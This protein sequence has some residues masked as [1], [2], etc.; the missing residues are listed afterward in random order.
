[1]KRKLRPHQVTA[2]GY[3]LQQPH[4]ALFMDMRLGKTLVVIRRVKLMVGRQLV[5]VACPSSAIGSW[6]QELKMEGEDYYMLLGTRKQ[7]DRVLENGGPGW[8]IINKEGHR[9]MPMLGHCPWDVVVIDE[10]TFIKNPRAAVTKF[11]LKWFRDVKHRFI[12]TGTPNPESDMEY[13]PQIAFLDGRWLGFN[14]FWSFRKAFFEQDPFTNEFLPRKGK[15][16]VITKAIGQRALVMRRKDVG[17]DRVKVREVRQLELPAAVRKTYRQAE[18]D[19]ELEHGEDFTSTIWRTTTYVW[20]RQLCGGWLGKEKMIWDGKVSELHSLLTGELRH[21]P[22]VVW[23]MYNQEVM[24][25][26][27]AL[28]RVRSLVKD[29]VDT[30]TGADTIPAREKKRR[31]FQSGKLRVLLIQQAVAQMGMDLSTASTAIYYSEPPGLLASKQTED[32]ILSLDKE[33]PLLYVYLTVQDSVDSDL[34]SVMQA[35]NLR[36]DISLSRAL[37]EAMKVRRR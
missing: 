35:K 30:M 23:F 13:W 2:L 5:L 33:G 10:S 7:R 31:A 4:P 29:G 9:S 27:D 32:R 28:S 11:H 34:R 15:W 24:A 17:L 21:E 16:S 1:M 8:Y 14:N 26:R 3:C 19:F 18:K 25:C 36:S 22:V 6:Q 20:C 12:L 37:R